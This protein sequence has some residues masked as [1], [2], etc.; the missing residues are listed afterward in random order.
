MLDDEIWGQGFAAPV[1]EDVFEVKRQRL[2]KDRHLKLELSKPGAL[3]EAVRF[4]CTD[5]V[6]PRIRAAY[7]LSVNE[8]QGVASLQLMLEHF[9]AA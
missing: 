2:M 4:N 5:P 9:E 7:R 6:P 1:F 8:Y 3:F